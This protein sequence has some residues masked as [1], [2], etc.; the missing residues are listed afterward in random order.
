M[1]N[2]GRPKNKTTRAGRFCRNGLNDSKKSWAVTPI[3]LFYSLSSYIFVNVLEQLIENAKLTYVS[4]QLNRDP[5]SFSD[6]TYPHWFSRDVFLWMDS[7]RS[8]H[9]DP[10]WILDK[11][12]LS[13]YLKLNIYKIITGKKYIIIIWVLDITERI[14][15]TSVLVK[16]FGQ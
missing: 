15:S 12:L 8:I 5:M 14:Q 13:C 2:L 6:R 4:S 7:G 1:L 10:I 11:T 3:F 16:V 9:G